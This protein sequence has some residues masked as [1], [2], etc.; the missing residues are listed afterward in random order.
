MKVHWSAPHRICLV[1]FCRHQQYMHVHRRS[2]PVSL[3]TAHFSH[4]PQFK[5]SQNF[6]RCPYMP[7]LAGVRRK[8]AGSVLKQQN[9]LFS[10]TMYKL[11]DCSQKKPFIGHVVSV[12][13]AVVKGTFL[14]THTMDGLTDNLS[15]IQSRAIQKLP[16]S[17]TLRMHLILL[18]LDDL[19]SSKTV[20]GFSNSSKHH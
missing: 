3:D 10:S 8:R 6:C 17:W 4:E 20:S 1:L 18:D 15:A 5:A 16:D 13:P 2:L 9:N 11:C 12:L 19:F 14:G 7:G